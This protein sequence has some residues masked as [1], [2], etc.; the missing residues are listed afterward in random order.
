MQTG[1]RG[2]IFDGDREVMKV[3]FMNVLLAAAG[4]IVRS[5]HVFRIVPAANRGR[6]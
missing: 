4:A 2:V 5:V 3:K 6:V 1:G